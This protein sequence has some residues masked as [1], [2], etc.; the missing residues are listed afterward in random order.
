MDVIRVEGL[1]RTFGHVTAVDDLRLAVRAGEIFGLVGP[2][3]AGKTTTM[4]LLTAILPPTRG[5]AWSV[6]SYIVTGP[7]QSKHGSIYMS[8]RFGLYMDLTV[9]GGLSTSTP[10]STACLATAAPSDE[11]RLLEIQQPDVQAPAGG[12][13]RAA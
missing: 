5:D 13:R 4:R 3:G 6:R 1:T 10:T 9:K 2:D 11:G 12:K 7:R 8:Q